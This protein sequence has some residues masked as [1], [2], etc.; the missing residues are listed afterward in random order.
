MAKPK[1]IPGRAR[2]GTSDRARV[3][4]TLAEVCRDLE[5]MEL[6]S[7]GRQ[8]CREIAALLRKLK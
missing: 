4:R 3:L 1:P 5:R 6:S 2:A 7:A 8:A